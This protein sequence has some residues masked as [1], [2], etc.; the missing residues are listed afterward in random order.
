MQLRAPRA[1]AR[2]GTGVRASGFALAT[3][4]L[5]SLFV[6]IVSA[7]RPSGLAPTTHYGYF[8]TWMAGP[9]GGL[10]PGLTRDGNTLRY[11]FTAAILVMFAGYLLLPGGWSGRS[12]PC[13]RSSSWPRRWP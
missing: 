4:V 1:I 5:L 3:I 8:P 11:I 6:V 2:A 10:W 13:T 7:D 12:W 9:L